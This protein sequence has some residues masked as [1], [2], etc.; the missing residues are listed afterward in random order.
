MTTSKAAKQGNMKS[1]IQCSVSK[2]LFSKQAQLILG[3]QFLPS[4]WHV[5]ISEHQQFNHI[6]GYS[7]SIHLN[8]NQKNGQNEL[9]F[10]RL[11]YPLSILLLA[12]IGAKLIRSP[13]WPPGR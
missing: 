3:E 12:A 13:R 7:G 8:V 1:Q 9:V 5:G 6:K 11:W 10:D 2:K 4:L